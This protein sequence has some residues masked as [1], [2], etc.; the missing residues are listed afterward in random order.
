MPDARIAEHASANRSLRH[1]LLA[2]LLVA[3]STGA[4]DVASAQDTETATYRVTFQGNW[5]T[6]STPGGVVGS[7][8]FT[9][10]IGA[11]HNSSV[12]FWTSG[13][14]ASPGIE[15]M[16]ETGFTRTLRREIEAS[17]HDAAVIQR[18]VSFGGTGTA[19]FDLE[20][21]TDHPLI[22]LTSMI[23]PSPDWFVGVSGVSLLD[24]QGEW[25]AQLEI[26]MFPYDAGTEDGE[27]FSL[28]NDDTDPQG[29][30][31]SL[32]GIGKF[33]DEPMAML[34]FVRQTT[35]DPPGRV[36][37][38]TAIPGVREIRVSWLRVSDADGYKVQWRSGVQA[39]GT[40]RQ[41]TV[42]SGNATS[43]TIPNLRAGTPYSV[44]VIATKIDADD[45]EP[46]VPAS[47][48]PR[49]PTPG[50]VT[51]VS[52]TEEVG[53]LV[54][55]WT[56]VTDATGYKVQWKS[57]TQAFS[58]LRQ[59]TI[60]GGAVSRATIRSLEGGTLYSLRV[61]AT[62]IH[63]NDGPPSAIRTGT[64]IQPN[65]PPEATDPIPMQFL[66]VGDTLSVD[67]ASHFR[68][69]E[70]LR[71]TFTAS[72]SNTATATT[73]VRGSRLTL[74]GIAQGSTRIR[75]T[76][77]DNDGLTARQTFA[78]MVGRVAFFSTPSAS[79]P[80]GGTARLSVRL[81]RA[82]TAPTTLGYNLGQDG[83]PATPNADA[84]DHGGTGGTVDIPA[85]SVEA[86]IEI[87]IL[88]DA[89]IEPPRE[90]FTVELL[91]PTTPVFSLDS[92][93]ATVTVDEGVCD[94]TPQ[95]RDAL[96]GSSACSAVDQPDLTLRQ[97]LNLASSGIAVVQPRDFSALPNLRTLDLSLN[98]L[99]TLPTGL[100]AG[101]AGLAELHLHGNPG[102]PFV[103]TL[104]LVRVGTVDTSTDTASLVA[105]V[106]EGA[107][108]AM[109]AGLS[110]TNAELS[111]DSVTVAAGATAA[112]PVHV[113]RVGDGKVRVTLT[114]VPAVPTTRCGD[115]DHLCFRGITTAA[116]EPLLVFA[117]PPT[118][119]DS[120]PKPELLAHGDSVRIG[121]SSLFTVHDD[122]VLTYTVESSNPALL[123][124]MVDGGDLVLIPNEDDEEGVATISVTATDADGLT[125][126]LTFEVSVEYLPRSVLRGWRRALFE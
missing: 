109:R 113:T 13:G 3:A 36:T 55:G 48:T 114:T 40:A 126:I 58:A 23:G 5:T 79:A 54:V 7:A 24:T 120:P 8:H 121:L 61:V 28:N 92:A 123:A 118:P 119:T 85:H 49:A 33:S 20:V 96:R 9:T 90:V 30:I 99:E 1:R 38:V 43:D 16:A 56:S 29:V 42:A 12:S 14:T 4:G 62:R 76:A 110:A 63:A 78:A 98:R 15:V 21:P 52:V 46:S 37:G 106:A 35:A 111:A 47:A 44:R 95:V 70:G 88:D 71:M 66:E 11:V 31:T 108:F 89:D 41:R 84:G 94:R 34:S 60:A 57:G 17:P 107:P 77:R 101:I 124:A 117:S 65:R 68:D 93:T 64:P 122:E 69:P 91:P 125:A 27:E 51:G 97:D 74:R 6:A 26:D 10:L 112:P 32:K 2:A 75:V 45:G 59:R 19:T 82:R 104:E 18:G 50:Q 72:S 87:P 105:T 25:L 115:G 102:A 86:V 81:S 53:Q 83:D 103:L 73:E 22:T 116:G 39:F 100:F 67:L 80:E